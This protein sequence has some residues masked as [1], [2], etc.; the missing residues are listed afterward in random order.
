[1]TMGDIALGEVIEYRYL[2]VLLDSELRFEGHLEETLNQVAAKREQ[3]KKVRPCLNKE[4][5]LALYKRGIVP[6]M[7]YC[8]IVTDSGPIK[9]VRKC[10]VAQN[11][12]LCLRKKR[13]EISTNALH[14]E[15]KIN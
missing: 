13:R 9:L 3:L 14:R 6:I 15:A 1:M 11:R 5:A 2:G 8:D 7:E 10:Q 4:D 12:C